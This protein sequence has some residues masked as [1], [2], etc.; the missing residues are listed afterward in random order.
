MVAFVPPSKHNLSRRGGKDVLLSHIPS[1]DPSGLHINK[2]MRI[3][4]SHSISLSDMLLYQMKNLFVCVGD[5]RSSWT[6]VTHN[7]IASRILLQSSL[8]GESEN[9]TIEYGMID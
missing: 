8:K 2:Q 9:A 6:D 5:A 7:K 3:Q 1:K 4:G